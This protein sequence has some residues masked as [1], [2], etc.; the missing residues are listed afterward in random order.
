VGPKKS[1]QPSDRFGP[2]I[3][4]EE[5]GLDGG[6]FRFEPDRRQ[7]KGAQDTSAL[8]ENNVGMVDG[9]IDRVAQSCITSL[10]P[11]A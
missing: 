7:Q 11:V 9:A 5:V 4:A 1:A 10:V 2:D 8:K 3:S 6:L